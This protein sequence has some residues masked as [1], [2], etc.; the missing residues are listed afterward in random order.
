MKG[1]FNE[2]PEY[3]EWHGIPM[4]KLTII[5]YGID[6]AGGVYDA[7]IHG[8]VTRSGERGIDLILSPIM[9][10]RR[11]MPMLMFQTHDHAHK[12]YCELIRAIGSGARPVM[13]CEYIDILQRAGIGAPSDD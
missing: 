5:G 1:K 2:R 13:R 8:Y 11:A 10:N 12:A 3:T 6:V 7:N 9:S 4:Q